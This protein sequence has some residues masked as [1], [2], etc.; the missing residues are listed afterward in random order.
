VPAPY[1][2]VP[3]IEVMALSWRAGDAVQPQVMTSDPQ[4]GGEIASKAAAKKS[5]PTVSEMTVTKKT[6]VASPT[7][8]R[9][10]NG[11]SREPGKLEVPNMLA[12]GDGVSPPPAGTATITVA[13]G[14][15]ASGQHFPAVKLTMRGQSYTLQDVQVVSCT[16]ADDKTDT[17]TLSY[18]AVAG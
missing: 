5:R 15:C 7:L 8:L 18:R 4:E 1:P 11:G 16:P 2:N 10:T 17:C 6:D 9:S 12:K 13:R 3:S 14:H